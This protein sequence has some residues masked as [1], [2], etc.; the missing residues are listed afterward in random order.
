MLCL[1]LP[2][3]QIIAK[4]AEGSLFTTTKPIHWKNVETFNRA[5]RAEN[6]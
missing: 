2:G 5:I 1:M 3:C 6:Q 4:M